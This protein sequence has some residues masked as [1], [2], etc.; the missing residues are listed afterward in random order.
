VVTS[1]V[2]SVATANAINVFLNMKTSFAEETSTT[3]PN[4]FGCRTG[5]SSDWD[6]GLLPTLV[7]G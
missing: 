7:K 4:I 6:S 2:P 3:P 1:A 5:S